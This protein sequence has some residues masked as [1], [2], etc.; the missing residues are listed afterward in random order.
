MTSARLTLLHEALGCPSMGTSPP[1]VSQP[2]HAEGAPLVVRSD[3]VRMPT[4]LEPH[5]QRSPVD[6]GWV[7]FTLG[8]LEECNDQA[9]VDGFVGGS[10]GSR[11]GRLRR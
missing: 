7:G 10:D 6:T 2:A 4:S 8:P 5:V 11:F 1:S 3:V 9:V